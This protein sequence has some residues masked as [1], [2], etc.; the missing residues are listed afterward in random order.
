MKDR[1]LPHGPLPDVE[2]DGEPSLADVDPEIVRR[3]QVEGVVDPRRVLQVEEGP[4]DHDEVE[5]VERVVQDVV[6]DH[7]EL[8]VRLQHNLDLLELDRHLAFRLLV[9]L[10]V[11]IT[12]LLAPPSPARV[13]R[14]GHRE[15]LLGMQK[16]F[17]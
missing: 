15:N 7:E 14:L 1:V 10:G 6:E 5:A 3:D 16:K 12:R 2:R 13:E 4:L 8:V 11:T 9:R 17:N